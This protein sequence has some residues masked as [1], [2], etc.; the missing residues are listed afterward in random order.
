[1]L[2]RAI[3]LDPNNYDAHYLRGRA[4]AVLHRDREAQREFALSNSLRPQAEGDFG[5]DVR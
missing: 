3:S 4:L 2:S 1:M 5:A